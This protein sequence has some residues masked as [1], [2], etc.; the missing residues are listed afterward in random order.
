MSD[1]GSAIFKAV[2]MG[3]SGVFTYAAFIQQRKRNLLRKKGLIADGI[4][5]CLERDDDPESNI[6]YP[7]VQFTTLKSEI[8]RVRHNFGSYP[9]SFRVGQQVSILYDPLNPREFVLGAA[10]MDWDVLV[11]GFL[12]VAGLS[13]GLFEVIK[14]II[15]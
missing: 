8:I 11:L 6:L 5:V 9:A 13:Y 10:S 2:F 3:M 4:V 15:K 14:S 1:I 12:G 7:V